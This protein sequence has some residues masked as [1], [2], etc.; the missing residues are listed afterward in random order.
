MFCKTDKAMYNPFFSL[1]H[2]EEC[3]MPTQFI[4]GH[5]YWPY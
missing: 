1:P 2:R 3:S 4:K 5:F